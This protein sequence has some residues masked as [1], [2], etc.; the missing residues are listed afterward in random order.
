MAAKEGAGG[1]SLAAKE[2][3]GGAGTKGARQEQV[4]RRSN[5]GP[6]AVQGDAWP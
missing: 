4:I 2:G 3:A 1:A 5:G 6:E